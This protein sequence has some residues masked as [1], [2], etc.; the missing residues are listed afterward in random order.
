MVAM[1]ETP[2]AIQPH[3]SSSLVN[4]LKTVMLPF[5]TVDVRLQCICVGGAL[6]DPSGYIVWGVGLVL[7]DAE[8]VGSNST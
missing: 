2:C 7:L 8:T 6:V 3:N 1:L 5:A 4:E